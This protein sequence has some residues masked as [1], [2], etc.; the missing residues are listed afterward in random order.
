MEIRDVKKEDIA[1]IME[2]YRYY[3]EE[4]DIT[5]E[6]V[7]PTEEEFTGRVEKILEKYPYLVAQEDG[8]IVGYAY[9]GTFKGR[10]AYDWAVETTVYV[11]RDYHGKGIGKTLYEELEKLLKEQNIQNLNACI[12]FPNEPSE[13][14]HRKMRVQVRTMAG[15]D[16]DAEIYRRASGY[17]CKSYLEKRE[18]VAADFYNF[19]G[20]YLD[21][22]Q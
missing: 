20:I 22:F 8:K 6:Y 13:A 17:P 10:A 21:K 19:F 3:V 9:A 1:G 2:I 4:T 11:D 15:Y 7:M 5:F 18:T 14:F 12:T 16:L